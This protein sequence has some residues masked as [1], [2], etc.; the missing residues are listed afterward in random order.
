[1]CDVIAP[2]GVSLFLMTAAFIYAVFQNKKLRQAPRCIFPSS[3]CPHDGH[4]NK[5]MR[6]KAVAFEAAFNN[7]A[8]GM[9]VV[10]IDG[11]WV[12]VN[13]ALI[14][15]LGYTREELVSGMTF[16]DVTH[17]DDLDKDLKLMQKLQDGHIRKYHLA[18]R[19]I[20]KDAHVIY[21]MLSVSLIRNLSDHPLFYVS[22]IIERTADQVELD[23][24]REEARRWRSE[25][26]LWEQRLESTRQRH[27]EALDRL[28]QPSSAPSVEEPSTSQPSTKPHQDHD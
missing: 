28:I 24:L 11:S 26:L 1:M 13:D 6:E 22:Q 8:H 2:L 21:I 17:P 25:A 12:R 7:A 15:M 14:D 27:N 10:D 20:R 3:A 9:A 4:K 19:Y 23:R 18:K 5:V 16:Q